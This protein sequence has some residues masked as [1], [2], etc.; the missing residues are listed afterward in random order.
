MA[1][2]QPE[3]VKLTAGS[4]NGAVFAA[5]MLRRLLTVI[6]LLVSTVVVLTIP[7]LRALERKDQECAPKHPLMLY[8]NRIPKT[9]STAVFKSI[10]FNLAQRN[11][12]LQLLDLYWP[13]A[14]S[15]DPARIEELLCEQ[16]SKTGPLAYVQ[17]IPRWKPRKICSLMRSIV[18][19]NMLRDPV[20][21][22][23][24]TYYY[25]YDSPLRPRKERERIRLLYGN[26]TL[27]QCA[28]RSDLCQ[29]NLMTTYLAGHS[30][31][32]EE[33]LYSLAEQS[34]SSVY[35]VIG[36]TEY[37]SESLAILK[38]VLPDYFPTVSD[39]QRLA[40]ENAF[41]N[42][43]KHGIFVSASDRLQIAKANA[44]DV[45]LYR[46]AKALFFR[47]LAS[48]LRHPQFVSPP[49]AVKDTQTTPTRPTAGST[50]Q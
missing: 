29:R 47:K 18:Y 15:H 24:S 33:E 45:R 43:A 23:I 46:T 37:L 40:A 1:E 4:A 20:E 44:L 48:C 32:T 41:D 28:L 22:V 34:M 36:I 25:L 11:G 19:I 17:H 35:S 6:L 7:T 12:T 42:P 3:A 10:Q 39:M 30:G 27:L 50:K 8:Y 2:F 5:G 13:N 31:G 21:R 26:Q 14:T 49:P 16:G 9:G 38:A